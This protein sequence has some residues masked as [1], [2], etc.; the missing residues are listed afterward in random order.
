[1]AVIVIVPSLAEQVEGVVTVLSERFEKVMVTTSLVTQ[2]VVLVSVH[3]KFYVPADGTVT[4]AVGEC[5]GLNTT[6]A[7]PDQAPVPILGMAFNVYVTTQE[8]SVTPA[9]A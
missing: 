4:V 3:V 5:T 9:L 7:G 1:M 8:V 6:P 2:A